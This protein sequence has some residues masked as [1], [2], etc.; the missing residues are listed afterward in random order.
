MTHNAEWH[1]G[2][3]EMLRDRFKAISAQEL[4]CE[5]EDVDG[6]LSSKWKFFL[7]TDLPGDLFGG[8]M[9]SERW[10]GIWLQLLEVYPTISEST[11]DKSKSV[12]LACATAKVNMAR[13]DG[14]WLVYITSN[15][16]DSNDKSNWLFMVLSF[17]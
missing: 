17:E 16:P 8:P 12:L 13:N 5:L 15:W 4:Q 11:T 7:S 9:E 10:I 2:D 3:F 6:L 1:L 14:S